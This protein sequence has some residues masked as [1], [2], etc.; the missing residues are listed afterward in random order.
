[1][2]ANYRIGTRLAFGF[3]GVILASVL[4]FGL[5]VVQG[6]HGQAELA[7][8][9]SATLSRVGM[10]HGMIEAQL[11]LVS[12]IRNAGLQT[13]GEKIDGDVD[14]YK[15][16]MATLARLE[17]EFARLDVSDQERQL[18]DRASQLRAQ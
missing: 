9:S 6:R 11:Q 16:A 1:M 8:T 4:A 10:V 18:V 3:G 17:S 7:E 15:Q 12:S 14:V 2:F 13:A 5:A